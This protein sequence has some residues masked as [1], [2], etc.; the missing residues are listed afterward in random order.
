MRL[1]DTVPGHTDSAQPANASSTCDVDGVAITHSKSAAND[2]GN[3]SQLQQS[4]LLSDTAAAAAQTK[5]SDIPSE[6][7]SASLG[8]ESESS[9]G[10]A[11]SSRVQLRWSRVSCQI[12]VA[13]SCK[14][15]Q[16]LKECTGVALP[17]QIHAILGPSG[18]GDS[19]RYMQCQRPVLWYYEQLLGL[20]NI[21]HLLIWLIILC[22]QDCQ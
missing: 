20:K 18:A 22:C 9:T 1:Q 10:K 3:G 19:N 11:I 2:N 4:L 17:G 14:L 13:T 21:R 7:Q 6:S 16:I 12:K 5:E 15:K 8:S